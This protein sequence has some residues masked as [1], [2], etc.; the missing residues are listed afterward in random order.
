[1]KVKQ[2]TVEGSSPYRR[3]ID[4]VAL[5]RCPLTTSAT[6][7]EIPKAPRKLDEKWSA[8]QTAE[9]AAAAA[10]AAALVPATRP[11]CTHSSRR[12][13]ESDMHTGTPVVRPALELL[14]DA[15]SRGHASRIL[16]RPAILAPA[17]R[18]CQATCRSAASRLLPKHKQWHDCV[19]TLRCA[20]VASRVHS[21]AGGTFAICN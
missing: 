16:E 18:E 15:G 1:M 6:F 19:F 2:V 21:T 11:A 17:K 5:K 14:S 7:P 10:Q 4:I 3:E 12:C 8:S 9:P 20:T 13:S